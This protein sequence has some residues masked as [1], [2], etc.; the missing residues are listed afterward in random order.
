MSEAYQYTLPRLTDQPDVVRIKL[1]RP[2]EQFIPLSSSR[3]E[4]ITN[5]MDHPEIPVEE[6]NQPSTDKQIAITAGMLL[7]R[8]V[9]LIDI[10]DAVQ[11]ADTHDVAQAHHHNL[12]KY[13]ARM[14]PTEKKQAVR[15]A[16]AILD[17]SRFAHPNLHAAKGIFFQAHKTIAREI[18][19]I[20]INEAKENSPFTV[21][22][23]LP[24]TEEE[25]NE[26]DFLAEWNNRGVDQLVLR[27]VDL[28]MDQRQTQTVTSA[29]YGPGGSF[30][31]LRLNALLFQAKASF[32]A[33]PDNLVSVHMPE[34]HFVTI[35]DYKTG[36]KFF[37]KTEA[38]QIA[39]KASLHLLAQMALHLPDRINPTGTSIKVPVRD[40]R[41]IKPT[42]HAEIKHII[43]SGEPH[44]IDPLEELGVDLH[45]SMQASRLD[46]DF[47]D[48]IET[49]RR[50]ERLKPLLTRRRK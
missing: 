37:P 14:A 2:G 5:A 21:N 39:V 11:P 43:L 42:D 35:T 15:Q 8:A 20:V 44:I 41:A 25:K 13:S 7:H 18:T 36:P 24:E 45:D 4:I 47:A 27:A 1:H 40:I 38:G 30:S 10:N 31:E 9:E 28:L 16:L 22:L 19:E 32:S 29:D 34:E 17:N 48:L 23:P 50:D 46:R 6:F 33:S 3:L 12:V 26:D 49:I